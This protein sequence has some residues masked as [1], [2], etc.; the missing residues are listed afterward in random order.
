MKHVTYGSLFKSVKSK[1]GN[2]IDFDDHCN[3]ETKNYSEGTCNCP[4]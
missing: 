3:G 1:K 4:S 2:G